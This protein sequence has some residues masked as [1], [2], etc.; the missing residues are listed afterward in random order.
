MDQV[1]MGFK[2]LLDFFFKC[3]LLTNVSQI[4]D[5][6]L[7]CLDQERMTRARLHRPQ[8][9]ANRIISAVKKNRRTAVRHQND[10]SEKYD[11]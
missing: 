4:K 10:S 5:W 11:I 1:K 2:T 6:I 3:L 9:L 7:L 8:K